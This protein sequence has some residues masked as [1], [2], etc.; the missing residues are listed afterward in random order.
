MRHLVLMLSLFWVFSAMSGLAAAMEEAYGARV[1]RAIDG[2]SLAVEARGK[3][4][5]VRLWG[6]DAPEWGQAF[7]IESREVSRKLVKGRKVIIH[8]QYRDKFDRI[9][10]IVEVDGRLLN[11]EMV[12]RGMAWVS[13]RYCDEDICNDWR[14]VEKTA[15]Q[16]G[17]GLWVDAE[18]IAPWEW[19]KLKNHGKQYQSR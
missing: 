6:I 18:P 11:E 17:T 5:Q 2:D 7:S 13:N 8:P 9:V 15:K 12:R 14:D 4:F 19:K 1:S 16:D 10:A 3:T